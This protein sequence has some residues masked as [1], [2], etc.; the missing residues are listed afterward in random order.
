MNI[1][2]FTDS[3]PPYINGV[4]TSVYNLREAL[5]KTRTHSLYSNSK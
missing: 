3:Y 4:A 5:K 1:G 2:L